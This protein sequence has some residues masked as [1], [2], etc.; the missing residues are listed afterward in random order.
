MEN[1]SRTD[2]KIVKLITMYEKNQI[3]SSIYS[4]Q[5]FYNT[6]KEIFPLD[7]SKRKQFFSA[8]QNFMQ[9]SDTE[10]EELKK[11]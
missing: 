5:N 3:N 11:L 9:N 7:L 4:R 1:S 2:K 6:C 10:R 8:Q